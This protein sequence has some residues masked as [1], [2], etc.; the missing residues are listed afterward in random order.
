MTGFCLGGYIDIAGVIWRTT[1]S[2]ISW[3]PQ[4]VGAEPINDI[5]FLDSLNFIAVGGDYEYGPSIVETTNSG[6]SWN[7]QTLNEFGIAY[8]VSFRTGLEAWIPLGFSQNLLFTTNKG[9]T[10]SLRQAPDSAALYDINFTD[11]RNGWMIGEEGK[12][13]KFN[14]N[15]SIIIN[16]QTLIPNSIYLYQNYPNPFNPTTTIKYGIPKNGFVKLIVYDVLGKEVAIL[17]NDEQDAGNYQV[18]FDASKLTSGVYFYTISFGNFSVVKRMYT[19]EV[20]SSF[21]Y[22]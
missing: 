5:E 19:C 1:N 17:V 2:G 10:W 9:T 22:L 13:Y 12:I 8:A 15:S 7:Y 20:G 3:T 21:L 4:A 16:N 11:N 6:V 14:P 18:T